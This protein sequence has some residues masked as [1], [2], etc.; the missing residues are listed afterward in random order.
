MA[1]WCLVCGFSNLAENILCVVFSHFFLSSPASIPGLY[2]HSH[3]HR[4]LGVGRFAALWDWHQ[5][6]PFCAPWGWPV[7]SHWPRVYRDE[8]CNGCWEQFAPRTHRQT[9]TS[10]QR[11]ANFQREC[12]MHGLPGG[13]VDS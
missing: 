1:S 12:P 10:D 2:S 6:A 3:V 4:G 8:L 7:P 11:Q 5:R 9:G 13:A